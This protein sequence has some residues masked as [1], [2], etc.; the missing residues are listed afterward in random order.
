MLKFSK[1]EKRKKTTFFKEQYF[2]KHTKSFGI[3]VG[4]ILIFNME[5]AK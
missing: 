4:N 3:I 2:V 1:K 5:S